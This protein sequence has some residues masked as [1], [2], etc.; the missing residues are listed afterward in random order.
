MLGLPKFAKLNISV[1]ART[2]I[3]LGP[4][5]TPIPVTTFEDG[6]YSGTSE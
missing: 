3:G 4:R 2:S 6:E 1:A 5:S